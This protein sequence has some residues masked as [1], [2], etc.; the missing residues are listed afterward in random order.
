[1]ASFT[2]STSPDCLDYDPLAL[3]FDE[4]N[5]C[6]ACGVRP[7]R[8]NLGAEASAHLGAKQYLLTGD[9]MGIKSMG[10]R[11]TLLLGLPVSIDPDLDLRAVKLIYEE[12]GFNPLPL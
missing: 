8:C 12:S 10:I 2:C 3:A 6:R 9:S 5:W 1:M 7:L 4:L 11:V